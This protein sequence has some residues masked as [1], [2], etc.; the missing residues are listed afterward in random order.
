MHT[1][2]LVPM[3]LG[4]RE[5]R[6]AFIFKFICAYIEEQGYPPSIRN[7][8]DAGRSADLGNLCTSYVNIMLDVLEA[9]GKIEVDKGISRGIRVVGAI[10][11]INPRDK[12]ILFGDGSKP[13][14][15]GVIK[16]TST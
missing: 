5:R 6:L 3:R 12:E 16:G 10:W 2:R 11:F 8:V 7:I 9:L 13:H 14:K 15:L 1:T 4:E